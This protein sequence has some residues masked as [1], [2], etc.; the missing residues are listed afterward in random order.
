MVMVMPKARR[1]GLKKLRKTVDADADVLADVEV[2]AR[3]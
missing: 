1:K 3:F 2:V